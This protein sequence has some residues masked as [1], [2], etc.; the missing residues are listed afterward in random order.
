MPVLRSAADTALL[1]D[2]RIDPPPFLLT[3]VTDFADGLEAADARRP[4][5]VNQRSG[6]AFG[7]AI[8]PQMEPDTLTLVLREASLRS[9]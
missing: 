6:H 2:S 9:R 7:P 5:A 1:D 8:G 4:I 3:L